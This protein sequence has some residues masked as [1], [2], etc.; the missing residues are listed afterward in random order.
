MCNREL[1]EHILTVNDVLSYNSNIRQTCNGASPPA[2]DGVGMGS[3]VPPMLV[4]DSAEGSTLA[5]E[6]RW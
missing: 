1:W 2:G 6:L 3:F 5:E 4:A